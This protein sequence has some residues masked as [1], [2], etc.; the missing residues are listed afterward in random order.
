MIKLNKATALSTA[1]TL[2]LYATPGLV[3][4]Q[5][6]TDGNDNESEDTVLEEVIVTGIRGSLM[7]SLATKRDEESRVEVISAEDI[8]K[9]PDR[10]IA[11]S[12]QRV[13]GVTI[14]AASANEGAFDEN[15][16]VSMRGTS[17]SYTQT[18]V[19]GHNIGS[20]DW[21]VLNQTG[22]VG[23]SVSYSLL[24]SELVQQVVVR[25]SY[26][27]KLVEGGLTGSVDIITHS[28]LNFDEGMTFSG[29]I[30][31]V[32]SE[33][34][35]ETD[36]QLSALFNWKNDAGTVGLMVQA[37]YQT[38]HLRRD[39]QELLGYN[40]MAETDAAAVAYPELAGVLY[41]SLIGSALFEQERQRTGGQVTFEWAPSDDF[42]LTLDGF[43]SNLEASNYNRNYMLWGSRI[44]QGGAVP[45]AGFVVRDNTLVEANFSA[46]PTRQ[47][48]IYDQISRPGDESGSEY[49][50]AAFEWFM[51]DKWSFSGQVG[52]SEG[53]GRTPTQ[54]VAEWD[55]GLGSGAA[56][57]LHGVGAAD[58]SL[59]TTD[60]SQ[61]GTPLEDMKLDWI[62]GYQHVDVED[63]EDWIQLDSQVQM[64]S[65][66][67]NSIDFGVRYAD[68]GRHLDQ[69]TA[70]GP[71]CKDSGGNTVGWD[72]GQQYYC[73]PGTQSPFDP[74]NWPQDYRNYPGNFGS[75]LGGNFPRNIWYYSVADLAAYNQFTDRDPVTRFYYPAVYG[76]DETSTAAYMQFNFSGD[77]WSGNFGLRYVNTEEDVTNYV[78][79]SFEDPDA[80]T[81]SA[82]GPYKAVNT[83]NDYDD[84]LPTFNFRY[85]LT[86]DM[87]LRFAATRTLAR[88]DYSALAGSVSLL[89]PAVE[90]GVGSGSGGN[91]DLEPI[92]ST[93]LDVT[94]EWYFAD[95]ALLSASVYYMDI[96]NYVALGQ[97]MRSIFTIDA[98]NPQGRFVDYLLTIP[99][100]SSA[101]VKGFEL[102]WQQPFGEN[103]GIMAN[104][105]YS[106]GDTQDG[107][108]MLGTSKN[109]WNLSGYFETD[110]FSARLAYNYRS[111]FYSGLDRATAFYQDDVQSLDG[112]I[113]YIISDHFTISLDG[114][115]LTNETIEYYA[116]SKERPRSIYKNGRQYYLNLRFNF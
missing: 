53:Y 79:A 47:Y 13:P 37:F 96:D 63:T 84:W 3:L 90:G 52:T 48:G 31:A 46:D 76:L 39:G 12:L 111:S 23:R 56:W 41:P 21:F 42:T 4:A 71:A 64:D 95:R 20:G 62:F 35:G 10:N 8:G 73:P 115:N 68:H 110:R 105:S 33:L 40:V 16:R 102:A 81:S 78:N 19:N 83:T 97:E 54:D 103:W 11:D 6:V 59:G 94:W 32:Y 70:Q 45:D 72:W 24:P 58:W 93:N 75:G 57:K 22:T 5:S 89:P 82:F 49:L 29:N 99:V 25:K 104:Y 44:I 108:P 67:L 2:A 15:D 87:D 38:R 26:E 34:P 17:P 43:V 9:M 114:R 116:D 106:D 74:A 36:P 85:N 50:S 14:S 88:A 65:N 100:N 112:T 18:L 28:P 113:G 80:I 66:W 77:R 1:I 61:P 55:L 27:A 69:V 92:L 91:P 101:E 86:D 98:Q 30:G 7:R 107:A 60:T 51:N 109:T